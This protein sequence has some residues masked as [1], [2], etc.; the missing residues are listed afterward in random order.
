MAISQIDNRLLSQARD[1]AEASVPEQYRRGYTQI[2]AAG[3]KAMFSDKTFPLMK[4]YL[5][6]I[7]S[8][9]DIPHVV[10]HGIIKLLSILFNES[11]GKLQLEASGPASIVLM[12]HALDY[13]EDVM[14]IPIDAN[15]LASTTD[16]VNKGLMHFLKQATKMSDEDFNQIMQGKGKELAA[17]KDAQGTAPQPGAVPQPVASTPAAPPA[18]GAV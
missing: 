14:K 4:E 13:V 3:L 7:K 18:E 10:A 11:R 2:L 15:V 8:P 5:A 12:T 17:S 6:S 9:Q 1:K 16:L